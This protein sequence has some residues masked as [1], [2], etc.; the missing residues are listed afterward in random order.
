MN[1]QELN[2]KLAEWAGFTYK[3]GKEMWNYERYKETNAWWEAPNGRR[4]K[5]LPDFT[6]SLDACF[7]WLVPN[8]FDKSYSVIITQDLARAIGYVR[9][10]EEG[11]QFDATDNHNPA[12]ALCLA[13]EKLIDNK[14]LPNQNTR[15]KEEKDD[16]SN[17]QSY[18]HKKEVKDEIT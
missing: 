4:F 14:N 7:K 6:Q 3:F 18:G 11:R 1:E 10:L 2:K 12:L 15:I 16:K 13:I 8:L 5:D 9:L 17:N